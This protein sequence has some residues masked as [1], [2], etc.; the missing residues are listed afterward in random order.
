LALARS[1]DGAAADTIASDL[2]QRFPSDTLFN[3]L[4]LPTIRAAVE[5]SRGN[6]GAAIRLLQP[7]LPFDLSKGLHVTSLYTPYLRGQAYLRAGDGKAAE[8][9]FQKL[10]DHRGLASGRPYAALAILGLARARSL[11]GNSSASRMAYQD[12]LALWKNADPEIPVLQ[13]A[14][15]EYSRLP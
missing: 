3:A 11:A 5:L 7:A 9:E 1:G 12:F 8:A 15:A 4:D 6:P 13:Q 2:A 10:I 14:R